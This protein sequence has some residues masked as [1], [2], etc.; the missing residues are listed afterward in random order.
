MKNEAAFPAEKREIHLPAKH[1]DPPPPTPPTPP[2]DSPMIDEG[3]NGAA[4]QSCR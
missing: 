4:T 2:S 3:N 1:G